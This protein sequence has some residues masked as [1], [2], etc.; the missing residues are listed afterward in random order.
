MN[1]ERIL[2]VEDNLSYAFILES[3]LRDM[4][5]ETAQAH[6]AKEAIALFEESD[7]QLVISDL[8]MPE[9]DGQELLQALRKEG[10][11]IPFVILTAHGSVE[12]AVAAIKSGAFDYLTKECTENEL[13]IVI[14]RALDFGRLARENAG[15][16]KHHASKYSFQ[17]IAT[18]S[19]GMR[20]ALILAERVAASPRT[21]VSI[22]GESGVGKEVLARAIHFAG[23]GLPANFV[24]VNCAAIPGTL[25]ESE[26]FGHVRGAFTGADKDREG[27][28]A[29]AKGGAL[30]LNEIGDMPLTLQTKLLRVLEERVY[31]K[32][33]SSRQLPVDFRVISSTHRSLESLVANGSFREDLYHRLSVFPI[34]IPPL[35]E[36][37]E[38]IPML[39]DHF[40]SL[41]KQHQGKALPGISRKGMSS[42]LEYSWPGNIRELR[43]RLER[44]AIVV[45]DELIRP[46]HLGFESG[47]NT[48][49][50]DRVELHFSFEPGELSLDAVVKKALEEI[51]KQC[52]G[53]KSLAAQRLKINRKMFN[54]K[55][56]PSE[57][58]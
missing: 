23:N 39:V 51:L 12:T 29:L 45:S 11:D 54:R 34:S 13:A 14:R 35:R 28:F 4:G 24:A 3:R 16:R 19:A 47:Q 50:A 48:S 33:G 36:R 41:F 10:R 53:N 22:Q 18:K 30:L 49:S 40:L 37:K 38:D 31:E 1:G 42:L 21:T 43:N 58:E 15:F 20:H 57:S 2:I 8:V 26:L 27:K 52:G 17:S 55:K 32:L 9:M 44:A 25:L 7:C 5:Y 46:E 6:S 56:P